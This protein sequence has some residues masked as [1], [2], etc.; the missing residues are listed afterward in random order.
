MAEYIRV[1]I[2]LPDENERF[3]K[4]LKKILVS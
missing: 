2:G 4:E 3:I 1:S